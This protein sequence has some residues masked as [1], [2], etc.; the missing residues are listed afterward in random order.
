MPFCYAPWAHLDI[1]PQ[2]HILPC[3]KYQTQPDEQRL[4]I[5]HNDLN[6]YLASD[7]LNNIKQTFEQDAWPAGCQRCQ[8]EEQNGIKSMRQLNDRRWKENYT[9]SWVTASL[10]F[11]NTCN[12]KCISCGPASSSKWY[13][14]Y[15]QVYGQEVK[16]VKFF[17]NNFVQTLLD[18]APNLVHMDI[19][20]GE[21]F[22]SGVPEQHQLLT[23]YIKTGQSKNITLHYT[24]NVTVYPD[25]TWWELWKHFK[26]VEIQLSIDGVGKKN[27]YIRYP[28]T[29]EQVSSNVEKYLQSRQSNLQLSVSHT[30]SAYNIYYLDEF[31]T[32]CYTVGLPKPW[33][34]RVHKPLHMRP[35]VWP[36]RQAIADHLE[37]SQHADVKNWVELLRTHDDS[38]YFDMFRTKVAEHDTYRGTDFA[39]TFPEM[40]DW[41]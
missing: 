33:L 40:K 36:N 1:N 28:S 22:L 13:E 41:L 31:F 9:D 38:V 16:P 35:T 8:I 19:P 39:T 21:P 29:W 17:K 2:G 6:E 34:G 26:Q 12:L 7:F 23:H 32:W 15:R 10:A 30:V 5:Q 25:R 4:D 14:E 24:T 27:E 37:K 20:G 18:H 3:C 11:G